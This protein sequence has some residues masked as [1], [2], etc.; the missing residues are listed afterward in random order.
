[1]YEIVH[2]VFCVG[3][4]VPCYFM[5]DEICWLLCHMQYEWPWSKLFYLKLFYK[6]NWQRLNGNGLHFNQNVYYGQKICAIDDRVHCKCYLSKQGSTIWYAF[7]LKLI[8]NSYRQ[9]YS[10]HQVSFLCIY[11]K[12]CSTTYAFI[13]TSNGS[14]NYK[15][16]WTVLSRYVW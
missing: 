15:N 4:S 14:Y 5:S 2:R 1:M 12:P 13:T 8:R 10:F 7:Q 16:A 6:G 3:S 11:V 9:I